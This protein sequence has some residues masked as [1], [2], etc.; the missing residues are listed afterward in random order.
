M[1]GFGNGEHGLPGCSHH[2][3]SVIHHQEFDTENYFFFVFEEAVHKLC[4]DVPQ[5]S[6]YI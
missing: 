4:F 5:H 6:T 3:E 2:N 1:F